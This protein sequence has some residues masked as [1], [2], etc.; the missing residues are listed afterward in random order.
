M[1][2]V[3]SP[4][5]PWYQGLLDFVFPPLC[6][7]CGAFVL[8]PDSICQACLEAIEIYEQPFCLNCRQAIVKGNECATCRDESWLLFAYGNY[9][10]PL[11]EI[12]IQFKFK[13]VTSPADFLAEAICHRFGERIADTGASALVPIPLHRTRESAR[14]YN[15]ADLLAQALSRRLNLPVQDDLLY[16]PIRRK[17]QAR[18]SEFRRRVNI[19]GVFEVARETQDNKS[20]ILVDDVVTSGATVSEA[21]QT[22]EAAGYRVSAAIAMAHGL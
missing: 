14:G 18:L 22:L 7:G 20:I 19:R 2:P 8:P 11:K 1:S 13:G 10:G 16:R 9:S 4:T 15:Q 21:R 6:L 3:A 17:P 12:V 5:Q